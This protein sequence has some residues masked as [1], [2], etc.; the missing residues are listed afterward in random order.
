MQLSLGDIAADEAQL[1][2]STSLINQGKKMRSTFIKGNDKPPPSA[3]LVAPT[4]P[5]VRLSAGLVGA[6]EA[7]LGFYGEENPAAATETSAPFLSR[8]VRVLCIT[9]VATV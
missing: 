9:D 1:P 8:F 6:A 5:D 7:C 3:F 4:L 2:S